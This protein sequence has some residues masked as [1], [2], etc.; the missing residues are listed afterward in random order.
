[1]D[2]N[3]YGY[4]V[5]NGKCRDTGLKHAMTAKQKSEVGDDEWK[6]CKNRYFSAQYRYIGG[7]YGNTDAE[8]MKK[9]VFRH[10]PIVIGMNV[11]NDFRR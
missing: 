3:C 2:E 8:S 6:A 10:G 5:Q 9:E 4:E 11:Q 1:M 7:Y